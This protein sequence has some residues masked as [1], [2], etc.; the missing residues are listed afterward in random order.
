MA[1]TT[2][3]SARA[4]QHG[5]GVGYPASLWK[6][7]CG[8]RKFWSRKRKSAPVSAAVSHWGYGIR[9][10]GKRAVAACIQ[11]SLMSDAS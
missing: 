7:S 2:T 3:A 8:A 6:S 9:D 11:F 10:G 1:E 5:R 4:P